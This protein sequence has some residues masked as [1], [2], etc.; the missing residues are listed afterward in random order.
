[1]CMKFS[2]RDLNPG[3]TPHALQKFYTYRITISPSPRGCEVI[4]SI[5]FNWPQK[6]NMVCLPNYENYIE[7]RIQK[8]V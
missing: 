3:L 2:P 5:I 1:M 4:A 7:L 8:I 6:A